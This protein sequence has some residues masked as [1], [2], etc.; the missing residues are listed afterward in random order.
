MKLT[1][2]ELNSVRV[3]ADANCVGK[4]VGVCVS[5][6]VCVGVWVG[7]WVSVGWGGGV[8]Y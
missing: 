7:V 8:N 4:C 6:W 5:V 1:Q 2:L 3:V